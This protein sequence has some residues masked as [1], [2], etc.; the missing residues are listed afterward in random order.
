[1]YYK[2][3]AYHKLLKWK[4]HY[5]DLYAI[6]IIRIANI[7]ITSKKILLIFSTYYFLEFK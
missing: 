1:M 7:I 5:S 3:K 6:Y 4:Q 2:R